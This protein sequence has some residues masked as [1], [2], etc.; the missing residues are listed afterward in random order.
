MPITR[1]QY[2]P[3]STVAVTLL[4]GGVAVLLQPAVA[5]AVDTAPHRA[6]YTFTL[7]SSKRTSGIV[8]VGG[9]MSYEIVDSCD[10]WTVNQRILLRMINRRNLEILSVTNYSSWE[11]KDGRRFRFNS[12]TTR[13]G[14]LR[15]RY[16][17]TATINADDTGLAV[18]TQ[19]KPLRMRLPKGSIFPTAHSEL[20][21]RRAQAGQ[22]FTWRIL[23]DGTTDEGPY[24]VSAVA[25][26]ARG[27]AS[28]DE[29]EIQKVVGRQGVGKY[30]P[31]SLAFF[32]NASSKAV[33]EYELRVGMH[34]NSIARWL[35]MDYGNFVID[36]RLAKFQ[37]LPRAKC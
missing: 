25:G 4:L 7:N 6:A 33:P 35:V 11:S 16:R 22:T 3:R 10:G 27:T 24:G 20:I 15:E 2:P 5:A 34:A 13:N 1:L 17:G 30:W 9:G 36:A 21:V 32:P 37:S 23:F 18:Y 8:D 26:R 31:V 28:G 29:A 12:R 14:S 19:P